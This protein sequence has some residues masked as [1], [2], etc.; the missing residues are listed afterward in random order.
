MSRLSGW[1]WGL[2]VAVTLLLALAA[3]GRSLWASRTQTLLD[4]LES[5]RVPKASPRYD[6]RELANLP[7]PVQRYF[8]AVLR[9]G[10]RVVSKVTVQHA[11]TFNMTALASHDMWIDFTSEQH[12]VTQRPGFVWN[13][14]M[15]LL[16]GLAFFVHDAY[17]AGVGTLQP[18]VMGL[19]AIPGQQGTGDI[20]RG[21]LMRYMMEAAWYPTALLPSQG[22]SWSAVDDVTADATMVDGDIHMTMRFTFNAAGLIEQID[23]AGRGA[24]VDGKLIV[25]PWQGRLWNY[26]ERDGM[27]VPLD[28]E[29]AWLPPEG[30]KTYWRGTIVSATYGFAPVPPRLSA[31]A[32]CAACSQSPWH[33]AEPP[34]V[35]PLPAAHAPALD[36]SAAPTRSARSR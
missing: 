13:A 6:A 20:A 24:M 2:V 33:G 16:P 19:F 8:R 3:Y 5:T 4:Q 10:Q 36:L 27:R 31:T 7:A 15:T 29:A 23:A 30:R 11:G 34:A 17:V 32:P 12:V 28:A 1:A 9:D 14:R 18:S 21:E 25:L 35:S 22:T 26:Q